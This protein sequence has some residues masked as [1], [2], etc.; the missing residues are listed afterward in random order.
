MTF[1]E[2]DNTETWT[3]K[4]FTAKCGVLALEEDMNLLWDEKWKNILMCQYSYNLFYCYLLHSEV[5]L[6]CV[7]GSDCCRLDGIIV[8]S[9]ECCQFEYRREQN[10][11]PATAQ[12]KQLGPFLI[13]MPLC[14]NYSP[15]IHN[16]MANYTQYWLEND[17]CTAETCSLHHVT[18]CTWGVDKVSWIA[19]AIGL[20]SL[21]VVP[22]V[23]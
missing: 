10:T 8:Y 20:C 23:L 15:D 17:F 7:K 12:L 5:V 18:I 22:Y 6:L 4:H 3:R 9:A 13:L 11:V 2:R 16:V 14:R 21:G 1:R 19:E